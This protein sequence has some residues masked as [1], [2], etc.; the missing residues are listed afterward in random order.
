MLPL[1][2]GIYLIVEILIKNYIINYKTRNLFRLKW[3]PILATTLGL[4]PKN[5]FSLLVCD[6][7]FDKKATLG[8]F[9]AIFIASSDD[10][11]PVLL[12][13]Y[14]KASDLLIILG[15]KILVAIS[16]G[17]VVDL[18]TYKYQTKNYK[19]FVNEQNRV[20]D[21]LEINGVSSSLV[22]QDANSEKTLKEKNGDNS[23]VKEYFIPAFL[24]SVAIFFIVLITSL[25]YNYVANGMGKQQFASLLNSFLWYQPFIIGLLAMIPSFASS[26]VI[27]QIYA[28]GGISMGALITG[29]C[30]NSTV[31]FWTFYKKT[32]NKSG[33]IILLLAIYIVS[34]L[35]GIFITALGL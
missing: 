28:L 11:I 13:N 33:V 27:T 34:V 19:E 12:G 9:V 25:V 22:I 16:L 4:V 26:V 20:I 17:F 7:Y 8:A 10:A 6:Y 2:I 31:V 14:S 15:I 32:K 21:N 3:S 35:V 29:L 5:D 30:V 24:H 1:F 18:I 23:W